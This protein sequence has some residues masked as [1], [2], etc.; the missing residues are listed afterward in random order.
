MEFNVNGQA[1]A[2]RFLRTSRYCIERIGAAERKMKIINGG[3]GRL[4]RSKQT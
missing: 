3:S 2:G 1:A 4:R